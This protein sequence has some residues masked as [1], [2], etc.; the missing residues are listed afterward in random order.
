MSKVGNYDGAFS[1]PQN[2][3]YAPQNFGYAPQQILPNP[4]MMRV[5]SLKSIICQLFI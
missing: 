5:Y 1:A 3:S 4:P 2:P